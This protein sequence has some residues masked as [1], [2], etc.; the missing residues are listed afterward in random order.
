M[1]KNKAYKE[2]ENLKTK[3]MQ[4]IKEA[5]EIAKKNN[6]SFSFD[7]A[8]GMGGTFSNETGGYDS[9]ETGEWCWQPSSHS[10]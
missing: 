5:E 4:L 3:A 1:S 9:D 8:Y 7:V 2:I 10:C 6:V